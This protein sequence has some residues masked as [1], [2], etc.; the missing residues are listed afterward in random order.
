[1]YIDIG[2]VGVILLIGWTVKY[3]VEQ[4]RRGKAEEERKKEVDRLFK[5]ESERVSEILK[6]FPDRKT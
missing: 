1:M 3:F 2:I 5:E 4:H 6:K